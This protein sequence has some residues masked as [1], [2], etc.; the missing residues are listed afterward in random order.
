MTEPGT[1]QLPI[2]HTHHLSASAGGL[3]FVGGAGDLDAA[4]RIR[5]PGD[6]MQQVEGAVANLASALGREFCTLDDV[7]RLKVHHA[8]AV[9]DWQVIAALARYFPDPMPAIS[10]VLEVM[11]PF[12]GQCLQL[13]AIAQRGWR[14]LADIRVAERPVPTAHRDLFAGRSV[15]AGLRA[16]EFIAV[17]NRTAEQTDGT[18]PHP[19]D[20]V[21]QSHV[22]MKAHAETLAALGASFQDCVKMEGYYFGET[23]DDWAPLAEAR[24]SHF[25]EP[26]P[27]ATVV[28][29]HRLNPPGAA[30]KIEV[31]AMREEWNGFDKY[32]PRE[33]HWPKRVW[34]WPIPLPYRQA[35][36]LRDTLWLGG[37]V[38]S[39]P[40]SN[41]GWFNIG[42]GA[43][44]PQ[45]AFVMS[46][47]EDLLRPF[48]RRL[49]DLKLMVCYFA[50]DGSEATTQAFVRTLADCVG[51]A[52]P[53]LTLVP[54]PMMHSPDAT[55]EIWGVAQG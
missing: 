22:I 30:T 37:Q 55:V 20:G 23:H 24:A 7:V 2:A 34:D 45:T 54:K 29:C 14:T 42:S 47:I 11:Q 44:L 50:S 9:D 36:R 28:P 51:G 46:Y 27:C 26:G 53:P 8:G 38:P 13:Q 32:I 19:G 35:F 41:M 3:S 15:T 10:T 12:S 40:Y 52:L 6:V 5:H 17:A 18:M 49:S 39:T 25:R 43:L 31:M 21:A 16:G 33:D 4:G 1:W 48:G